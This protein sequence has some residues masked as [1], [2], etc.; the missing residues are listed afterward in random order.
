M[1]AFCKLSLLHANLFLS[2][3]S[4]KTGKYF[5]TTIAQEQENEEYPHIIFKELTLYFDA[6]IDQIH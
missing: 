3:K 2:L 4:F 5:Y 1:Q 6:F